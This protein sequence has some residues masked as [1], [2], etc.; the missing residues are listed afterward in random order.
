M[1]STVSSMIVSQVGGAYSLM[2]SFIASDDTILNSSLPDIVT[3]IQLMSSPCEPHL[4]IM[5]LYPLHAFTG[6]ILLIE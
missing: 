6:T 4:Y 3:D 2:D 1:L 5:L